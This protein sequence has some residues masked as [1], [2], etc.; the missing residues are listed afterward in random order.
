MFDAL[1]LTAVTDEIAPTLIGG[2]VQRVL[3]LDET[4]M[5]LEIY[6]G[7]RRHQL[8]LSAHARDA[9]IHLVTARLT[10][11]RERVTPFL[12]LLRKYLR[13][14]RIVAIAQPPLERIVAVS[15]AKSFLLDKAPPPAASVDVASESVED[16]EDDEDEDDD[17][18]R[19][20]MTVRL[21]VE[22]MGR[23]SNIILHDSAGAIL[24][25][26]KRVPPRLNRYRTI[27][28][29]QPYVPPPAQEKIEPEAAGDA[30][31][32][33]R[34]AREPGSARLAD[35]LVRDLRGISPQI[36]REVAFRAGGDVKATLA[37]VDAAAVARELAAVLAPLR[38]HRWEPRLYRADG[39]A[40]AF[41]PIRLASLA[42][43]EEEARDSM[44]A[45]AEAYFMGAGEVVAHGQAR[46]QLLERLGQEREKALARRRSLEEQ[47]RAAEEADTYRQAGELIYG[48]LHTLRPGQTE[49][50]ADG[51]RVKLDPGLTPVENAQA[52]FERYR[53]ARSATENLPDLVAAA[54]LELDYLDQLIAFATFA[55][56]L[57]EVQAVE[58]EWREHQAREQPAPSR[59][60]K[61]KVE[62][63]GPRRLHTARGDLILIGR[64]GRQNEQVTFDLSG[65]EAIWLHA[66]GLPGAHVML[67]WRGVAQ[68][69]FLE[70]AARLAAYYSPAREATA[71]EV[72]IT[73]R[74][75]V[76]K[77]KGGS[78]GLVTY[79]NERTV[80]V[81]PASEQELRQR[82]LLAAEGATSG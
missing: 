79:R 48:Y 31:W 10:A 78:P 33:R 42:E 8:L 80:R 14:G 81:A 45:V 63:R 52:C 12:L 50:D 53:R 68:D 3:L 61:V 11:D 69:R 39:R 30:W 64:S 4:S 67:H 56:G 16:D 36:A 22:I 9:R 49:L 29:R 15:I 51:V 47:L 74:R 60:K 28:P 65:P 7:R 18:P 37:G 41:S 6:A 27:L 43:L 66:R 59:R 1:T 24:D 58:A 5:G 13:G 44:S 57:D 35:V 77:I 40:V 71:V 62:A 26:I 32:A 19:Y 72:D 23:H 54:R 70:A 20:D 55:E 25:S 2:R 38:S 21:V 17:L 76:R 73:E 75:H 34:Q 82:G 46:G